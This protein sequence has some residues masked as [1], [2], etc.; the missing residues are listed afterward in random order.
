MALTS[1][2]LL[3]ISGFSLAEALRLLRY[4]TVYTT[5]SLMDLDHLRASRMCFSRWLVQCGLLDE[6]DADHDAGGG[7]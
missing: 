5:G 2:Q 1:F 4:K 6:L 7:S 3:L